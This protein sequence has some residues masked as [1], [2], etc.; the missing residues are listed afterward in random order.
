MTGVVG[1]SNEEQDTGRWRIDGDRWYRQW[2]RWNYAEEKGY[3]IVIDGEQIKF[4]NEDQQIV[5]SMFIRLADDARALMP[6]L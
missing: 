1:F 3:Y 5:D 4:F 6:G 2:S